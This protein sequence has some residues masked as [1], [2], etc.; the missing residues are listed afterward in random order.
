[1]YVASNAVQT[2]YQFTT[3]DNWN[4]L[5]L[6]QAISTT[7]KQP[8]SVSITG[9]ADSLY[10]GCAFFSDVNITAY[11]IEF[12]DFTRNGTTIINNTI[13]NNSCSDSDESDNSS[14]SS[15]NGII[16]DVLYACAG[17]LFIALIISIFCICKLR[18]QVANFGS[19]FDYQNLNNNM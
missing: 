15:I 18:K 5:I 19:N 2:I 8:T 16:M 3:D 9:I 6:T 1:M 7:Y 10:I 11:P 13:Y 4:T 14:S 12:I 17:V